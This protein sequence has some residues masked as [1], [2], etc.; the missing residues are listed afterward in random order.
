MRSIRDKID[1]GSD[2]VTIDS[3][4]LQTREVKSNEKVLLIGD[5]NS[6]GIDVSEQN[7]VMI[8]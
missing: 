3:D 8:P 6:W 5:M 7:N 4:R 1:S 2:F